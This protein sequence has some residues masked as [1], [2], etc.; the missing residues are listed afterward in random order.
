M[1]YLSYRSINI[2]IC[3]LYLPAFKFLSIAFVNNEFIHLSH[4]E[5]LFIPRHD[6]K[7]HRPFL[8]SWKLSDLH[9]VLSVSYNP[10]YNDWKKLETGRVLGLCQGGQTIRNRWFIYFTLFSLNRNKTWRNQFQKG[11]SLS[12]FSTCHYKIL[13]VCT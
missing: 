10:E 6:P 11:C 5:H 1:Y 8:C 2:F 13:C 9:N 12:F 7:I 3:L 4:T